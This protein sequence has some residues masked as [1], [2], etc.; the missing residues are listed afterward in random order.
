MEALYLPTFV[1]LF[2]SLP[3]NLQTEVIEKIELFKNAENNKM[4][5]VHKLSGRLQG[6][7]NFSVNYKTRIVF[8][9]SKSKPREAYLL[10]V[11]DHEIYNT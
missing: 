7:Y 3:P 6:R 2:K 9:Y 8:T 1:R 11:G 5:K 4:L 10:A